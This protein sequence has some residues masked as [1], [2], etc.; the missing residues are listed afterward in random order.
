MTLLNLDLFCY[1]GNSALHWAVAKGHSDATRMLLKAGAD[2]NCCNNGGRTALHSAVCN[3]Q[4]GMIRILVVEG[5]ADP[6]VQDMDGDTPRDSALSVFGADHDA[7][8]TID[9]CSITSRLCR[10]S[11]DNVRWPIRDM[12]A[13]LATSGT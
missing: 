13:L 12:K 9:S 1:A 11:R 6:Q 2:P 8:R 7:V 5:G 4:I 3:K 10:Y